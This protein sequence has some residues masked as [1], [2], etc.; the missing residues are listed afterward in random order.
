ML[1]NERGAAADVNLR[2]RDAGM[3]I[4]MSGAWGERRGGTWDARA[5]TGGARL[6]QRTKR[7]MNREGRRPE[8]AGNAAEL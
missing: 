6:A 5:R 8:S 4:G 3:R 1:A 7:L 2:R